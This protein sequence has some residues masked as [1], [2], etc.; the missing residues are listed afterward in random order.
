MMG[1]GVGTCPQP[2]FRPGQADAVCASIGMVTLIAVP[3]GLYRAL[4]S[5]VVHFCV[6]MSHSVFWLL[7]YSIW[8]SVLL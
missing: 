1:T 4:F 2:F 3:I 6:G 7:P 5:K 8:S